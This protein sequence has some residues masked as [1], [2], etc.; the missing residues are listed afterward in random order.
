[1]DASP[2]PRFRP[3]DLRSFVEALFLA[4]GLEAEKARLVAELLVQ[5]DLMGHTTHGLALAPRY[6]EEIASG[7]IAATGQPEVIQDRGACITWNGRG[8]PGVWLAAKAIDLAAERAP[9][10]G[11]VSVAIADSRHIASLGAYLTRATARGF[12][13]MIASSTPSQASVA[14]FGGV[15][16]V[17]TP[18]PV[19]F[20]IP[21]SGDP[22]LIDVSAT[23]TTANMVRRLV[24]E[25]RQFAY[26]WLMEADGQPTAD[27]KAVSRGGTLQLAGGLD[28]GHK[29]YAWALIVEALTQGLSGFGRAT[30]PKT[31]CS[32]VFM[33]VI[34][35]SAFAGAA[36]CTQ[37]MDWLAEACRTNPPRPGVDRVRLPGAQALASWREAEAHGLQLHPG[38]LDGL[39][40]KAAAHGVA[41]P[42]P[43]G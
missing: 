38:L 21:T 28:H 37:Q 25:G 6:L 12:M 15:A 39:K 10:Y 17:M 42:T 22:I 32:S 5:A 34:D 24:A 11:T 9:T 27:P 35:P 33:Q 26:P 31:L 43:V 18:N 14:P 1:M 4:E 7:E 29:G 36:A 40:P 30:A 2:A 41:L 13:A 16:G 3:Q 20:G 19:A 23:I 8:L